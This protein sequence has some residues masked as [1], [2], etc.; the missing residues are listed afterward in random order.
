MGNM[1]TVGSNIISNSTFIRLHH[2]HC[3]I[4]SC[5]IRNIKLGM[6]EIVKKS[7]ATKHQVISEKMF[8]RKKD[9]LMIP[10]SITIETLTTIIVTCNN[11]NNDKI[12]KNTNESLK[13]QRKLQE[14][15]QQQKISLNAINLSKVSSDILTGYATCNDFKND[16]IE[17]LKLIINESLE[18]NIE[19]GATLEPRPIRDEMKTFMF[20]GHENVMK[21]KL[22]IEL[23]Y[24]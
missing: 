12:D 3:W 11:S 21:I 22:C 15:E 16:I 13:Q 9:L 18:S 1:R 6:F 14:E 17:G 7:I 10:L 19:N 23:F 4:G 5:T 20:T 8:K 24:Y 2:H